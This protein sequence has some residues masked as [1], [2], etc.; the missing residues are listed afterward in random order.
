[1]ADKEDVYRRLLSAT[2]QGFLE[3]GRGPVY[4]VSVTVAACDTIFMFLMALGGFGYLGYMYNIDGVTD[5]NKY[6]FMA[7]L[8]FCSMFFLAAGVRPYGQRMIID[9]ARKEFRFVFFPP[10]CNELKLSG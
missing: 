7:G 6:F 8:P 4:S 2:T 1:M 3:F 5:N 9:A 10:G